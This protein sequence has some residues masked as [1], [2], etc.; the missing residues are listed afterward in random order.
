MPRTVRSNAAQQLV[1]PK[2]SYRIIHNINIH[3]TYKHVTLKSFNNLTLEWLRIYDEG[4]GAEVW[5]LVKK[6]RGISQTV[7]LIISG[8]SLS[9]SYPVDPKFTFT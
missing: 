7:A 2:T 4:C 6:T 3:L 5:A 9:P 1:P 8:T